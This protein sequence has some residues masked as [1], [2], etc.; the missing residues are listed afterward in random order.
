M[1]SH[2]SMEKFTRVLLRYAEQ[3][4]LAIIQNGTTVK[5]TVDGIA[6]PFQILQIT[7]YAM[8]H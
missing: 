3:G 7:I 5:F 8:D 2:S 4:S 1:S 6:F